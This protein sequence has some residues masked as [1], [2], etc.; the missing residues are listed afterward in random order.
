LRDIL[1]VKKNPF[2]KTPTHTH[3]YYSNGRA[4]IS[5]ILIYFFLLKFSELQIADKIA[6]SLSWHFHVNKRQTIAENFSE[7]AQVS[8]L[9]DQAPLVHRENYKVASR[10]EIFFY[11]RFAQYQFRYNIFHES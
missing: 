3:I 1:R 9:I 6:P 8:E 4:N 5:N 7:T 2:S 11:F 10:D